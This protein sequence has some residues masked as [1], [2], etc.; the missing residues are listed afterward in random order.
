MLQTHPLGETLTKILKGTGECAEVDWT[1]FG[2]SIAEWA[3]ISFILLAGVSLIQ[4]W[5]G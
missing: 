1:L 5:R 3:L 2:F 4:A